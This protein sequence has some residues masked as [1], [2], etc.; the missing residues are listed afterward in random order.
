[1]DSCSPST[2]TLFR[3][4]GQANGDPKPPIWNKDART[5][6]VTMLMHSVKETI[7]ANGHDDPDVGWVGVGRYGGASPHSRHSQEAAKLIPCTLYPTPPF[8]FV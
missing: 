1:M 2:S 3:F 8:L 5:Q 4:F 6:A 7:E